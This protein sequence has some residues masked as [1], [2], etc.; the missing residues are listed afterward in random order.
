[1]LFRRIPNIF[2]LKTIAKAQCSKN[3][4]HV[5]GDPIKGIGKYRLQ[6]PL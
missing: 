5:K 1:M 2:I 3:V 4:I 6:A